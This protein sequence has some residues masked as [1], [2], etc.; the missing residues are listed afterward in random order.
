MGEVNNEHPGLF[1]V[2]IIILWLKVTNKSHTQNIIKES[3][4]VVYQNQIISGM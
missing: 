2:G 1:K 3:L 4:Q